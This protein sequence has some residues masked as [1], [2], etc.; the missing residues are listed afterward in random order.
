MFE[1]IFDKIDENVCFVIYLEEKGCIQVDMVI[2]MNG[3]D[4]QFCGLLLCNDIG[5]VM[6]DQGLCF[7]CYGGIMVNVFEYCFKKM[8]GDCVERF[9]YKGYW[10]MYFINGFGIEDFFYFCEKV[11]FMFVYVVNVEELVQD[12]VDMIEYLNG[13]VDMKW[14]KKCV[15]NGYFEFY[16]LKYLEIGNEEVIWGDIEVDYQYYID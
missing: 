12:M 16:G 15:E 4:C 3:V 6:V 1:L 10:Y 8:I 13:L 11:G 14:G 2:F 5:Q 7:F 9:F